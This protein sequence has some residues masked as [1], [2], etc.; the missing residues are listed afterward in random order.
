VARED[1]P[2]VPALREESAAIRCN[3]EEMAADRALG[4]I[5]R[6]QMLA[7]TERA[8]ARLGEIGT[9]LERAAREDVLAPLVAADSA[10][11]EWETMDLS[12]KRA[13][14][15]TLMTVTLHSPGR[16]PRRTFDPASVKI[17]W[18]HPD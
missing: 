8:N 6:A 1:G 9:E 11:G 13:V 2:D 14:I 4:L 18:R 5:G 10:A 3:L 7:A 17:S 15:R 16:G 12:N